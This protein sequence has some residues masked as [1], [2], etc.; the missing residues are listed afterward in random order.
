VPASTPATK[1]TLL[2]VRASASSLLQYLC[3]HCYGRSHAFCANRVSARVA[4]PVGSRWRTAI[5][6]L[7]SITALAGRPTAIIGAQ[8]AQLVVIGGARMLGSADVN[9]GY[10][11]RRFRPNVTASMTDATLSGYR[12]GVELTYTPKIQHYTSATVPANLRASQSYTIQNVGNATATYTLTASCSGAVTTCNFG[13]LASSPTTITRQL[14]PGYS[15]SFSAY[16]TP[17]DV[18]T[19]GQFRITMT[20]PPRASGLVE[21]DTSNL[22]LTMA[23]VYSPGISFQSFGEFGDDGERW[24]GDT[25]SIIVDF[26]DA[27]GTI[28]TS[29]LTRD[30]TPI[31][32]SSVVS[33]SSAGT[34]SDKLVTF[35]VRFLDGYGSVTAT[36]SDGYHTY[37]QVQWYA[38]DGASANLATVTAVHPAFNVTAYFAAADSF[39]V[40]N[41]GPQTA[42]YAMRLQCSPTGSCSISP[43][44]SSIALAPGESKFVKVQFTSGPAG[45]HTTATLTLT[46]VGVFQ[47][48]SRAASFTADVSATTSPSILVTP[49]TDTTVTSSPISQVRIDWCDPDDALVLHDVTWQGQALPNTYVSTTRAGCYSAGTSTYSNLAINP[50][51]QT[52][53]ATARD[54]AN[55]TTTS[56]TAITFSPP[57]ATFAPH[58]TVASDIH[59]VPPGTSSTVAD[60][61][62]VANVG[63]N[64]A[65]YALAAGCGVRGTLSSCTLSPGSLSLA[66]GA[67]AP[68]I[69]QYT[70]SGAADVIDTLKLY[71][72]YTSPLGGVIADTGRKL[73]VSPSV[74]AAPTIA[75]LQSLF[76]V[77]PRGT[78]GQA[79]FSVRNT[80]SVPETFTLYL[81]A[82]SGWGF[83]TTSVTPTLTMTMQVPAGQTQYVS[84]GVVTPLTTGV[85]G[86]ISLTASYLNTAS[87]TLS[88]T[89]VTQLITADP[90]SPGTI[91][92]SVTG[93]APILVPNAART[94]TFTVRNT[95][96][97]SGVVT[98]T[99]TCSGA[100]I[101]ACTTPSPSSATLA[102]G[103]STNVAVDVTAAANAGP[104]GTVTLTATSGSV[105]ASASVAVS[106]GVA[107]GPVAITLADQLNP[108][109]SIARDQCLTIAAGDD[110]A[111][112]CGD[113]RL[114]HPL[115]T[116]TTMN[117]ARTPT[118]IYTSAHAHPVTLI[119][120][121]VTIDGTNPSIAGAC[122]SLTA[123]VRVGG[124]PTPSRGF[125]W[126]G[127]CNQ[128]ATRR[129]VVPVDAHALSLVTGAYTY[130]LEVSVSANGGTW[131]VADTTGH[132]V[133]VNREASA[134]GPGWWLD[135]LEQLLTVTGHPE[136]MLWIGGDGSTRVY[137]Q[138]GT[139]NTFLVQP[140]VDRPDTLERLPSS[141]GYKRHLRNGAYVLFNNS[142]QHTQTVNALGHVTQFNWSGNQLTSIV[143]PSGQATYTFSYTS[144]LL[145]SVTAP[146]GPNGPRVTTLTR[147]G[148]DLSVL[149]P[150]ALPVHYVADASNRITTRTNRFGDA[151]HFDYDATASVLTHS[152]LD[153]GRTNPVADSIALK[154]C[155]AEAVSLV[156]CATPLADPQTVRT[157]YDGPR[158]P[159]DV[160]DTAAFYVTRFGA[161]A[162]VIDAL[163]HATT[164][165]RTDLRWPLLATATVQTNG[166]RVEASYS[167]RGLIL[168]TRDIGPL[169]GLDTAKTQY[170]WDGT[171]DKVSVITAPTGV[172]SN[173]GYF[174]NGDRQWEQLG[175]SQTRRVTFG[176]DA[177]T[178]LLTSITPPTPIGTTHY[179]HDGRGNL[180]AVVSAIGFRTE[181]HRDVIGRDSIVT[182]PI[183]S[184]QTQHRT[185]SYVYDVADR[186]QSSVDSALSGSVVEAIRIRNSYDAEGRTTAVSRS[187]SPDTNHIGWVTDS[188]IY[189]AAG[190][191]TQKIGA[192]LVTVHYDA[193][194]NR[195]STNRG[196]VN[197]Y[198]GLN[199]L[200]QHQ[201]PRIDADVSNPG[202]AMDEPTGAPA[203]TERFSYDNMG[204]VI[205]ADN[206]Y[207]EVRR[208]YYPNGLL[209]GDTLLLREYGAAAGVFGT[210][211]ALRFAYNLD[212]QRTKMWHNRV[213][214]GQLTD[215]VT[216]LYDASTGALQQVVDPQG[217]GFTY[218]DD[219][220]GQLHTLT[221]PAGAAVDTWDY[222]A[223]GRLRARNT[224][225]VVRRDA[226]GLALSRTLGTVAAES[227]QFTYA[228]LGSLKSS[229]K[230]LNTSLMRDEE[231]SPDGFGNSPTNDLVGSPSETGSWRRTYDPG[232][233]VIVSATR[234]RDQDPY[235]GLY[236]RETS[237]LYDSNGDQI[238]SR[239]Y[240]Y[241]LRNLGTG[242]SCPNCG[243]AVTDSTVQRQT[244]DAN[245]R[246]RYVRTVTR[247]TFSSG[248]SVTVA[249]TEYRYDALGR[250]LMT[251]YRGPISCEFQSNPTC[252]ATLLHEFWD[253]ST[254]LAEAQESD[255]SNA[256]AGTTGWDGDVVYTHGRE[257]DVPLS[258]LRRSPSTSC[259]FTVFPHTDFRGQLA[260][261]T[262]GG[263]QP[264]CAR[265]DWP[266]ASTRVFRLLSSS[267]SAPWNGSLLSM[268]GDATG[269]QYMRNRYYDPATGQFTQG[270][271]IGLAGGMN[272]YG[273]AGGDPVNFSDPFGLCPACDG[274]GAIEG[275]AG[276][277]GGAA[278]AASA[279]V[280]ATSDANVVAAGINAAIDW[281]RDKTQVKFVTYTRTAADGQVYSGRTSGVGDPQAIV[282]ARAR[283]HPDRLDGFGSPVVDVWAT[284]PQGYVAIRGREQ[285]LIDAHGRAQSEGGRSA[286]IRRGVNK[287]VSPLFE[288]AATAKFGPPPPPQP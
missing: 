182:S 112:E 201:L 102:A 281:L 166:H 125:T 44:A 76:Q 37:S 211:A 271:P 59:R 54:A 164:I 40:T 103:A 73:V 109:T 218:D 169:G 275:A 180:S 81:A 38:H 65:A 187:V 95:G 110:A 49:H 41:P 141:T 202:W 161:P 233:G 42:T 7:G 69:A 228:A 14:L 174:A 264:A 4:R 245:A 217:Y 142:L 256:G 144:N 56:T 267:A 263:A 35:P 87:Q 227:Y 79:W 39:L 15:S 148:A 106:T 108:G 129:I 105:T 280:G 193:A 29:T 43:A 197:V 24:V 273:F 151:T 214:L 155:P 88:A 9:S 153:M 136:Q 246:L 127:A 124:T 265:V 101:A 57:L 243:Q 74:E 168:E 223:D 244:Y 31:A 198:D 114:V 259:T 8:Q 205:A 209:R 143:L 288:A 131:P 206:Q 19:T 192:A 159:S 118:L 27:D 139:S 285:Q 72:T 66:P 1:S 279:L 2:R 191:V 99:R 113:L 224:T 219:A 146:P 50:W 152:L 150:G 28:R 284:G 97:A 160:A 163:G 96:T 82:S 5:W 185:R 200:T 157:L 173:F 111:Y 266:A 120:A 52:L 135:G 47:T 92:L 183:D 226:R 126:T 247:R 172:S 261:G 177:T 249:T 170:Q 207:A 236:M 215:S 220:A 235:L 278:G 18:G 165:E 119:A 94:A 140:T 48:L 45:T 276:A 268:G 23:D 68:V 238:E 63:N 286:N 258:I 122:P 145:T 46:Y 254:L 260:S 203:E 167:D 134:F 239:H 84:P 98:F 17:G 231:F 138:Q 212:G 262:F 194:G 229:V 188:S 86:T 287:T 32:A 22:N 179:E 154:F 51:R 11:K 175:P 121:D 181:M 210:T 204:R 21:S 130:S 3:D 89:A 208:G 178:R 85:S 196:D 16:Y 234:Y 147:S 171:F 184:A 12:A 123:I 252:R 67:S 248:D 64:A 30:G 240:S 251:R 100:V 221:F 61:F 195:L 36:A 117:K 222:D 137:T 91:A 33:S 283:Q 257:L 225:D 253:G 199:R 80:S 242:T 104:S 116:T 6:L 277:L 26:Y 176:Y 53:V 282:N 128:L 274:T 230:G 255:P 189:D 58:V 25:A 10:A 107:N 272:L 78:V 241:A 55:H 132:L 213:S 93:T 162:K 133:I 70:R 186:L 115:P 62:T 13:Y 190:R 270:D 156:A 90:S 77:P 149:D 216:Y 83:M 250:R 34:H 71:A 60:T 269:L 75:P 158:L 232:T 237:Y 20:A